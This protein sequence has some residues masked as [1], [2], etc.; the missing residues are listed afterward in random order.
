V[1]R[2]GGDG[3][4]AVADHVGDQQGNHPRRAGQPGQLP[5]FHLGQVFAEGVDLLDGRPAGQQRLGGGLFVGQAEPGGRGRHQRRTAA[6]EEAEHQVVG[7]QSLQQGQHLF[8]AGDAGLVGQRMTALDGGKVGEGQGMAVFGVDGPGADPRPQHRFGGGG[9]GRGGLARADDHQAGAGFQGIGLTENGE[10]FRRQRQGIAHRALWVGGPEGSAK[11]GEGVG[12]PLGGIGHA[13][14]KR[15]IRPTTLPAMRKLT[16][17]GETTM[18]AKASFS[19]SRRTP[20][21]EG[22]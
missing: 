4:E 21:G 20:S 3:V 18:G 9:H 12:A 13:A 10:L 8:S 15:R 1:S 19:G 2:P 16:A 17:S 6:R 7:T 14:Q 5:A 22:W 11:D